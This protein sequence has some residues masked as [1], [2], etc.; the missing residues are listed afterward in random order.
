MHAFSLHAVVC[1]CELRWG[2]GCRLCVCMC[3][4][5]DASDRSSELAKDHADAVRVGRELVSLGFLHHVREMERNGESGVERD[6]EGET[7]EA[8]KVATG[9][10]TH[11]HIHTHT[12]THTHARTHTYT[13]VHTRTHT[14]THTYTHKLF[15]LLLFLLLL[16]L[17]L[18]LQVCDD[19]DFSDEYLFYRFYWDELETSDAFDRFIATV[20]GL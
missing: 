8:N 3:V 13:H 2:V 16:L 1:V 20:Q 19:H 6:G 9:R 15:L 17:L 5:T 7:G 18:L 12:H 14:Y 4:Y 11:T 10:H